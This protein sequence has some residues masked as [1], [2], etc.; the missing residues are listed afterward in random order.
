[1]D[2]NSRSVKDDVSDLD[3]ATVD[4]F[5][6]AADATF[7]GG[8]GSLSDVNLTSS[9]IFATDFDFRGISTGFAEATTF[10]RSATAVTLH[11]STTVE[12]NRFAS[13]FDRFKPDFDDGFSSTL[14]S[15]S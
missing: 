9:T 6:F 4:T 7:T 3:L 1:V 2:F 5:S 14:E 15:E 8:D 13:A 12:C 10:R 11:T